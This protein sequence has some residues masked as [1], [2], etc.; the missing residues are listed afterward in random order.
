M[1]RFEP[2]LVTSKRHHRIYTHG[3]AGRKVTRDK[4]DKQQE[5]GNRE[6]RY[7]VMH[8]ETEHHGRED[9]RDGRTEN[10]AD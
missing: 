7:W 6:E 3:A 1:Y 2:T 9:A 5:E 4:G 10:H 8:A